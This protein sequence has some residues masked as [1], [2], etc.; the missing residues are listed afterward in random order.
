MAVHGIIDN[1]NLGHFFACLFDLMVG[2]S[3]F[4]VIGFYELDK[5]YTKVDEV[6]VADGRC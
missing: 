2:S 4:L 6:I 5:V 3:V 1:G